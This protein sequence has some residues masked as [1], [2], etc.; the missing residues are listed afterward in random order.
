MSCYPSVPFYLPPTNQGVNI[1]NS[2]G[3]GYTMNISWRRA[4]ASS[5]SNRLIYN[6]Y[7]STTQDNAIQEGPKF[8]SNDLT[9]LDA[10]V[11]DFLPGDTYF[12]V[13]RAAEYDPSWYNPDLLPTDEFQPD[14][15]LKLYPETLLSEDIN[16]E[17]L[18][19]PI[20]DS[21]IFPSYGIIQVGYEYIRYVSK[22]VPNGTL[23]ASERGFLG[24]IPRLHTVDG[25]DGYRYLN[26]IVKFFKGLEEENLY[27]VQKQ[28]QFSGNHGIYTVADG[29]RE[30]NRVGV[31][32][33]DSAAND[34]DRSDFP[35]YDF[36][37]WHR[38][39]PEW[40]FKGLCVDTYMGGEMWCADGY[41]GI[42][43][44]VRNIKFEDQ[45]SR[46]QEMLLD[47]IGTGS[48]VVLLKRMWSGIQCRC[49]SLNQESP[50]PRCLYCYGTGISQSYEQY[51]NPRRSDGRILVRFGPV[52]EDIRREDSGLESYLIHDCW[53]LT[54][55]KLNDS[56]I[57]IKYQPDGVT[58]EW[59][60][61]ILDVTQ[62]VLLNNATGVQKFRAQRI[63]KT[64]IIYQ[65][66]R[67]TDTSMFPESLS[68]T[69]G[70]LR[71]PNNIP[72]PHTHEIVISE[73][74]SGVTQ[75]NQMTSVSAN[76]NH[77]VVNGVVSEVEG[78][79]H[80]IILH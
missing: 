2:G 32:V 74:I 69:V 41:L 71:G 47:D 38:T 34:Q 15:N 21:E 49:V 39:N 42:N 54:Y 37:G 26:P 12:F 7:Y 79:T 68:T 50:D 64:D 73:N 16:D 18:I 53:T 43:R 48:P 46:L 45:A 17:Q 11:V 8:C 5:T 29:Y 33:D 52:T 44:Q 19:I 14:Q 51:H 62:N 4:F 40:F 28:S 57:I 67:V 55:P 22:D 13:V 56:D 25:Y 35:A 78:H 75:I 30:F 66:P 20:T 63:R 36:V 60:Y 70:L 61:E 1:V 65:V 23:I 27:V 72:I 58:E 6:I 10:S 80:S 31:L 3:D 24:T 76:H 77:S 59:R 9:G